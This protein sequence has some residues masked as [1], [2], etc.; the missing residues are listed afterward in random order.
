[1]PVIGLSLFYLNEILED[2]VS[3]T[4]IDARIAD[5]ARSLRENLDAA[6]GTEIAFV[7]FRASPYLE[8]NRR[9]MDAIRRTTLDG[10]A[11]LG[12]P[13]AGFERIASLVDQ[14][15]LTM[16][17]LADLYA[18]PSESPQALE[19]VDRALFRLQARLRSLRAQAE[20]ERDPA[21]RRRLFERMRQAADS[22]SEELLE[23]AR[24]E[25]PD[26]ARIL[27]EVAG[28][29][30][31]I[32]AIAEKIE[33]RALAHAEVHRR[34]V[35]SLSNRAQRNL[36]T[37]IVLTG[38][39]GISLVLFLPARVVRS[40]RRVTHV[41]QQ[42]ER[43]DLDVA[44][45]PAGSDEVGKLAGHL[46]R[47]LRQ[48]RTFDALKTDRMLRAERRL[49]T[50]GDGLEE[51]IV[52]VDG[53]LRPIFAS[54]PAR[55]LLDVRPEGADDARIAGILAEEGCAAALR[56]AL[57]SASAPEDLVVSVDVG[58]AAPRRLRIRAEPVPEAG[59]KAREILLLLSRA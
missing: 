5:S 30:G 13:D 28:I 53:E 9:S 32:D 14:Y 4:Q 58:T 56:Q 47:L 50:L 7:L 12:A 19:E 55:R 15:D 37:T 16:T 45:L 21:A 2:V 34:H 59:G 48:V 29:R 1:M 40:L 44:A 49:Q 20:G 38:L 24:E 36:L 23:G 39:V 11:H 42:A 46:N 51:G 3:I 25:N 17:R 22:I 18:A 27:D 43:G 57:E 33:D 6:A 26:R 41:L 31:R 10:L 35:M 8:E 54:G 52:V